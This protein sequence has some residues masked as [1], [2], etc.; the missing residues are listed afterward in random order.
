MYYTRSNGEKTLIKPLSHSIS[1]D[2][3][4]PGRL[5]SAALCFSF[6]PTVKLVSF[7]I[8]VNPQSLIPNARSVEI[9]INSMH[10][11]NN[12][13]P[14]QQDRHGRKTQMHPCFFCVCL[15]V[16][17]WAKHMFTCTVGH[18]LQ[19]RRGELWLSLLFLSKRQMKLSFSSERLTASSQHSATTYLTT[20]CNCLPQT[21]AGSLIGREGSV[22]SMSE[23]RHLEV[24]MD[25]FKRIF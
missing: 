18:L 2:D 4:V 11:Y 23:T 14:S 8:S 12:L 10:E 6:C 21:P 3:V 19:I 15:L 5:L 20:W 16:Q 1:E 25:G 17:F 24:K 7:S 9:W 13:R 22:L